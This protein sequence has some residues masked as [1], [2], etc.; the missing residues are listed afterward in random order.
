MTSARV[1]HMSS[2]GE[3][4]M[5]LKLIIW[6]AVRTRRLCTAGYCSYV[7]VSQVLKQLQLAVS[8]LRE[9]WSAEWLHDLLDRDGLA[10]ELILRRAASLMSL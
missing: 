3:M 2:N 8:A 1:T 9:D 4:K 5:S 6:T 10:G 7:L